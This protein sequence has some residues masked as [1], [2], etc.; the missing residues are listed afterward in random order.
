[1]DFVLN[2]L[3]HGIPLTDLA[4]VLLEIVCDKTRWPR[5][6]NSALDAFIY[7]CP[8]SP[9]KV[10]KLKKL[11]EDVR[12]GKVIDS[13]NELLGTLLDQLYPTDLSP[14][15]VLHC[16]MERGDTELVGRYWRFWY[17]GILKKSSDRDVAELLHNL[18][19]QLS[20][21]KPILEDL[22]DLEELP[23][24]LLARGLQTQGN[25]QEPKRLYDWLE[26]GLVRNRAGLGEDEQKAV[27]DIR[28]WLEQRP[29]MQK[30]III[31]GLSRS[32]NSDEFWLQALNVEELLYGAN[33]PPDFGAWCQRQALG[34]TDARV[35]EYFVWRA[36]RAGVSL[37]NQM[38]RAQR[39]P[40]LQNVIAKEIEKRN[41]V[42]NKEQ[43]RT[44]RDQ[45]YQEAKNRQ[46][47][48]WLNCVRSNKKALSQNRAAP[49]LLDQMARV[50]FGR[51]TNSSIEGGPKALA[52]RLDGNKNLIDA[53]LQG[54]RGVVSRNDVPDIKE[55][56]DLKEKNKRH[57]L[58][59]PFLA[60]LAE[61]ERSLPKVVD[62]LNENQIRK[63]VAFYYCTPHGGYKPDWYSTVLAI[64]P[65]L[66]AD[67]QIEFAVSEFR[68]GRD[69]IYKLWQL[70]HDAAYA[71]VARLATLPLLGV[72]STRCRSKQLESLKSLLW[73]AV[74]SVDRPLLQDLI[75]KKLSRKSMNHAQ[76]IYWLA[77]GTILSSEIYQDRLEDFVQG[78]EGRIHHL[79]TFLSNDDPVRFSLDELGI[80]IQELLTRLVGRYAGPH[81][82]WAGGWET[83]A[84]RASRLVHDRIQYLAVS[85]RREASETL[86]ALLADSSLSLW[87]EDLSRA[88]D[89]QLVIRRDARYHHAGIAQVCKTLNGGTPANPDDLAALVVDRLQ[90]IAVQIRDGNTDGW[91][92]YWNVDSHGRPTNPRPENNCRDT[93]LDDLRH[94]LPD[95]VDA[96]SE[97][98]YANDK[99]ADIRIACRNFQ[100]PVE[101]KKNSHRDV[102]SA[103]QNQLIERYTRDPETGGYGIY[104]L[105]WFGKEKGQSPPSGIRPAD[106][107]D[108]KEKIEATLSQ[109]Q[110]RKI[111]VCVIDVSRSKGSAAADE[112]GI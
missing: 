5:V 40:R 22:F 48:A 34:A 86:T 1:M 74:Q 55:I 104:L 85:R 17:D 111:S 53:V 58:S 109:D 95:E 70:A 25:F 112:S 19:R 60:G 91:K 33:L 46:H 67:I 102:W 108:M 92:K 36:Y 38:K 30:A 20:T 99:R 37:K 107:K 76:R 49:S 57:Y 16:L 68:C 9:K 64:R 97:G 105:F 72:F 103:L 14:S 81:E 27:R 45:S 29:D 6:R 31:E 80:S 88:R 35:A 10:E 69:H 96:Q 32:P 41:Q 59:L 24:R 90:E 54:F 79:V 42:K 50:Y 18:H 77:A 4:D 66:V 82:M 8:D 65:D 78:Q 23:Q 26:V 63:A 94:R 2:V 73:A 71:E 12:V 11:L 87:H 84:M 106:A 44:R 21:L 61:L 62:R 56:F 13:D 7:H 83:P 93:L 28:L 15:E 43:E 75:G 110:A 100:V 39:S 98:Q 51:F 3:C 89:S 47:E 101:I 52:E